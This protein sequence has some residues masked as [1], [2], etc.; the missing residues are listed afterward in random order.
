MYSQQHLIMLQALGRS[1]SNDGGNGSPLT[2]HQ[3]GQVKQLL[4]L[5]PA[6]FSL[7]KD[8]WERGR[9]LIRNK[10]NHSTSV[11]LFNTGIQPLI[12]KLKRKTVYTYRDMVYI[13][14]IQLTGWTSQDS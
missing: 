8:R 9:A 1:P 11:Y 14:A 7:R 10:R 5:L 6:P 4:L 2:R 12:P 13:H 3:L